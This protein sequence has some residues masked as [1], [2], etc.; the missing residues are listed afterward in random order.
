MMV[1]SSLCDDSDKAEARDTPHP[2]GVMET[3]R[4]PDQNKGLAALPVCEI[5]RKVRK[6]RRFG[7]EEQLGGLG[8]IAVDRKEA[9]LRAGFP[10]EECF[11]RATGSGQG[12]PDFMVKA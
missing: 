5:V 4:K 10:R 2:G 6:R 11:L 7:L 9:G 8:R 3:V 12:G 1:S